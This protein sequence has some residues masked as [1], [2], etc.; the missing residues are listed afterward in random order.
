MFDSA[1]TGAL[2]RFL[3][4]PWAAD[5]G[6]AYLADEDEPE[7]DAPSVDSSIE[8]DNWE[9][10][11]P[12]RDVGRPERLVF[13]D[14]V[15]RIEAWGRIDHGERTVEAALASVAAG[16]VVCAER[17][18]A[19]VQFPAPARVLA[20]SGG[21][22]A[23]TMTVRAGGLDL[24]FRPQCSSQP[25]RKGV[26]DAVSNARSEEERRYADSLCSPDALVVL[27]G[28]L[29]FEP[30]AATPVVGLAKTIHELYL[31]DP[32]RRVLLRLGANERTPV[33]QI[34]YGETTR[35]SWFIRL[36]H[37]R[38]IHHALAGIVR[39]ETP[40]VGREEAIRLADL[41]AFH[42]PRFASRPEHDPRAPQNLVPVGA[43]ERWLRHEMGDPAFIR[44]AIE[45][46]LQEEAMQP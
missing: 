30:S 8:T 29:Q 26:S 31:P 22:S 24:D 38:P 19:K 46:H 41:T 33:F 27:D 43:L 25:G 44:R 15:Q 5:Y 14:G 18:A 10:P 4:D 17:R 23:E 20:V 3:L 45:Q 11:L 35:Y 2:P 32:E 34:T 37:V 12:A 9:R 13:V 21:V 7:R 36:P 28:R 16:A 39:L 1:R 40:E 6:S 42:L